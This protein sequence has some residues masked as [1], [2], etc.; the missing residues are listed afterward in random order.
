[1]TNNIAT[2]KLKNEKGELIAE[3]E[4][5]IPTEEFRKYLRENGNHFCRETFTKFVESFKII[6]NKYNILI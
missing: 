5:D 4:S 1:M 2:W 3:F 6:K